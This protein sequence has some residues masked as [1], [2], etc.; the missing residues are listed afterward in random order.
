MHE[1]PDS[2]EELTARS[3]YRSASRAGSTGKFF[4]P[5]VSSRRFRP[6]L[7]LRAALNMFSAALTS[8]DI[9]RCLSKLACICQRLHNSLMPA[10]WEQPGNRRQG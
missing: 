6:R 2:S 7:L 9:R 4:W 8:A 1:P 3:M 10:A 5:S